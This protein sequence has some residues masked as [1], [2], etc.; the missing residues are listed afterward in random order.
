MSPTGSCPLLLRCIR[1]FFGCRD[2]ARRRRQRDAATVINRFARGKS[3]RLWRKKVKE[4]MRMRRLQSR[5]QVSLA[6]D[7]RKVGQH[8]A[9]EDSNLSC[10]LTRRACS[11]SA[12]HDCNPPPV[13]TFSS[14]IVSSNRFR[15]L[16]GAM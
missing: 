14:R 2:L 4:V 6:A 12:K 16:L 9:K 8:R 11:H 5:L 1:G 10:L 15:W 13:V 3:A 7:T